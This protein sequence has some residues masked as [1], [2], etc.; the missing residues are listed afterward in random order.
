MNDELNMDEIQYLSGLDQYEIMYEYGSNLDVGLVID[1]GPTGSDPACTK[2]S[3]GA[4]RLFSGM[5]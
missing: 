5:D 3:K 4:K 2:K 1:K